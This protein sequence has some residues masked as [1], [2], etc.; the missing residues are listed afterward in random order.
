M[1]WKRKQDTVTPASGF[2]SYWKGYRHGHHNALYPPGSAPNITPD[3]HIEPPVVP[4]HTDDHDRTE[5]RVNRHGKL[6]HDQAYTVEAIEAADTEC[7]NME[8]RTVGGEDVFM[9][10]CNTY[11]YYVGITD[12]GRA[13]VLPASVKVRMGR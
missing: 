2:G 7:V 10:Q 8:G 13:R 12:T 9:V 6:T 5:V 1:G 4:L 11:S 3:G